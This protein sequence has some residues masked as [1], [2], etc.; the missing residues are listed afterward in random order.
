LLGRHRRRHQHPRRR[1]QLL[2]WVVQLGGPLVGRR[3]RHPGQQDQVGQP[4][5]QRR[6][7]ADGEGGRPAPALLLVAGS[8]QLGGDQALDQAQGTVE[9]GG[10]DAVR[11]ERPAG[12]DD[13]WP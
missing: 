5:Q 3:L 8:W 2:H 11:D 13:L 10:A 1:Q 4:G 12:S 7:V 6:D 9:D